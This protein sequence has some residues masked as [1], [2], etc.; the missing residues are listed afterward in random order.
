MRGTLCWDTGIICRHRSQGQDAS[1][2]GREVWVLARGPR[3]VGGW[4]RTCSPL[5]LGPGYP[6]YKPISTWAGILCSVWYS[7]HA[8]IW[9]E[10]SPRC[11]VQCV[12]DLL[13]LHSTQRFLSTI[14]ILLQR[15]ICLHTRPHKSNSWPPPVSR[16][17][18]NHK[19]A[20][21]DAQ[22]MNCEGA[23][24]LTLSSQ[25]YFRVDY[26]LLSPKNE[27]RNKYIHKFTVATGC[28]IYYKSLQGGDWCFKKESN[29]AIW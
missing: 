2:P 16:L 4:P 13:Q 8:E 6:F 29:R 14:Y 22:H 9:Q 19:K 7:K 10:S 1:W 28:D 23:C 17:K 5:H 26:K 18:L 27:L 11:L 12:H 21:W 3:T 25:P 20:A 24:K 15:E